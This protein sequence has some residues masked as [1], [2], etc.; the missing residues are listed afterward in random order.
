VAYDLAYGSV[1]I[2]DCGL[3]GRERVEA[4]LTG[5]MTVT[6]VPSEGDSE[7]Y[8]LSDIHFECSDCPEGLTYSIRGEGLFKLLPDRDISLDLTVNGFPGT[9]L[10]P[11][12]SSSVQGVWPGIDATVNDFTYTLRIIAA[13]TVPLVR[14]ELMEG[15]I[16]G[17]S[18]T[19]LD[20]TCLPHRSIPLKGT[21][22]L[23]RMSSGQDFETYRIDS[24]DWQS[25][26]TDGNYQVRGHGTLLDHQ[27]GRFMSLHIVTVH[28]HNR[29]SVEEW[30]D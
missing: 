19:I 30:K 20:A 6:P 11:T 12:Q 27:F 8:R 18:G 28:R 25:T 23:G 16:A 13:P 2:D 26:L 5:T 9:F 3:C 1:I 21:F 14:Y 4:S 22:L 7:E 24:I 10:L 29:H 17:S 15:D